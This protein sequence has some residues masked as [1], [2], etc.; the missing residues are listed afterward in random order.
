MNLILSR[1]IIFAIAVLM[2]MTSRRGGD[3]HVLVF[4]ATGPATHQAAMSAQFIL[5][6]TAFAGMLILQKNKLVD[7][8]LALLIDPPTA[9]MAFVGGSFCRLR[10]RSWLEA[11]VGRPSGGRRRMDADQGQRTTDASQEEA[12]QLRVSQFP[13]TGIRCQSIA[14]DSCYGTCG[15]GRRRGGNIVRLVQGTVNG[16]GRRDSNGD[17][18][19]HLVRKEADSRWC[20]AY[21]RYGRV[22]GQISGIL[23]TTEAADSVLA[24][25]GCPLNCVKSSLEQAGFTN[26]KHLQL[27]DLGL[28]KC[29]SPVSDDNVNTVAARAVEMIGS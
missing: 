2:T 18:C 6:L 25:D 1:V 16:S 24:I 26:F 9:I 28:E 29:K 8:K 14:D 13:G 7:W 10:E 11:P 20:G 5:M 22:G 4:G 15:F 21:V 27:A 12:I 17:C 19:R 23:K 3:F